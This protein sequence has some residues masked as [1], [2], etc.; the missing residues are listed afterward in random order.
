[1]GDNVN[2]LVEVDVVHYAIAGQTACHPPA[3]HATYPQGRGEDTARHQQGEYYI[4]RGAIGYEKEDILLA[5][6]NGDTGTLSK[7]RALPRGW[8]AKACRR[9]LVTGC[10]WSTTSMKES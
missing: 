7:A 4:L 2:E 3:G 1:M 5:H 10:W 9:Y 8:S 6:W